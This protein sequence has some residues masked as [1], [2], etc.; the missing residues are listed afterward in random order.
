MKEKHR[1]PTRSIRANPEVLHQ[2]RIAAVTQKK[3]LGQWLEEAIVEKIERE[4]EK[5]GYQTKSRKPK[6]LT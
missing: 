1:W 3:T 4:Q 2:A 5:K 6:T